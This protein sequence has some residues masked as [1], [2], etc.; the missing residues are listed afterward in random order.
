MAE[1]DPLV[2]VAVFLPLAGPLTYR[3]PD[4][5]RGQVRRGCRVL[6]PVERR[7]VLGVVLKDDVSARERAHLGTIK[8]LADLL[9]LEPVFEEELLELLRWM[10][11]YYLAPIGE[12]MR[13]ALPAA[14]QVRER[15]LIRITDEGRRALTAQEALLRSPDHDLGLD[16]LELLSRIARKGVLP[17]EQA[18][19]KGRVT[20]ALSRLL[21]R[22]LVAQTMHR[23]RSGRGRTDLLVELVA[24]ADREGIARAPRQLELLQALEAAGGRARLGQLAGRPKSARA[25]AQKLAARGVLLAQVVEVPRDPF[26][27][28]PVEVDRP[29]VL[30]AEQQR[31]LDAL[32]EAQRAGGFAA[33]LLHGV[34]G[35][36]KTEVYLRLIA[37]VLEQGRTG[38]VLVPEISLTP[39][40]AARFRARFGNQV[41]VLHSALTDAER[42][43]QWRLIRNQQVRIVVGARSA[44]FAPLARIGVVIV[45]EEHD[46]SFK[47]AEGLHYNGR[48]LALVR[49]KRAGALVVLGSATPSLE[50]YRGALEGRLRLLELPSRATPRPLPEVRIVDL[51]TYRSGAE[52]VL[53]APLADAIAATLERG[54]QTILF[55][56][57]RGFASFVLCR[58]C[59]HAFRCQHCSVTLTYHRAERQRLVCHY[60]GYATA[61][62][63]V[64]PECSAERVTLLGLGTE[65]VEEY[66]R[67]RFPTARIARLDRDTATSRGMRTILAAV[68]RREVDIL[69]GT[70]MVT[71][72]HDFP[73]VTLVGVLCADLGLHFPDFRSA[74][75]TFQLLTQVAGRAGRGDRPGQ[76]LIQTY[77][78][79]HVSLVAASRH[80]FHAFFRE[81][82]LGRRE[83]GYPPWAHLAAIRIDGTDPLEVAAAARSLA[84]AG[85]GA[86]AP[87]ISLLGPSEAPI[88]KLKG[89][90]R[91]LILL[92][93]PQREPLHALLAHLLSPDS[94]TTRARPSQVR[95][96]VDVDPLFL[97]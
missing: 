45:D 60:C 58:A 46:P 92:K 71:K 77:S 5:L 6:V 8:P 61:L 65:Q 75:R 67:G 18:M 86:A 97:L 49:A 15:Q 34:T 11:G 1:A 37:R 31:A 85:R 80:D 13:A 43:G 2:D 87:G 96:T 7:R 39:Q 76:V 20:G 42:Y 32:L 17:L 38:L 72:G 56:N 14:L 94:P 66:L 89:R 40:L 44:V 22:A 41:A 93:A 90:T 64:C 52:G 12:A 4:D 23:E 70:Q 73:H 36:G 53:S 78:P 81:E 57:R 54:E 62:P 69:V 51:R 47:Q 24:G 10:A 82:S 25:I 26:A 16:E 29:P 50:S 59:G 91:W 35:S 19:R 33:F 28:E 68:G 95:V 48:D 88:Q 74:E 79:D 84:E 63:R 83:L 3:V 27:A 21:A 9:D 30:T 55:L